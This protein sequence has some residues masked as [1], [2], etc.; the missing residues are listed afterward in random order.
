MRQALYELLYVIGLLV[1]VP[2]GIWRMRLPHRGWRMRLG[3]YD[4]EVRRRLEGRRSIW[5]HAVSVG[6]T[7]AAQPLIHGLG[8][9][10]PRH[11]LVLS[12]VTPSGFSVA[13]KGLDAKGVPIYFPLDL[14]GCV[15]RALDAI[16]PRILLLMES[17]LWPTVI[18]LTKA[19]GIPIAVV[20]GR[21]SPRAFRRYR[22]VPRWSAGTLRDVDLFLM[23]SQEDADRITQL[24]APSQA[25]RVVGNLKWEASSGTRPSPDALRSTAARLGLNG[26]EPL[27]VAGS[28]HRGEEDALL[29]AFQA[30]RT[31]HSTLRLIIAP[32]HLERLDEI[33]ALIRER[34]FTSARCSQAPSGAWEVGLVDTFG[35]LPTYYGLAH[36]VFVGG[37][38]IPHGGQNPLEPASLGKPVLFGPSMH[39]FSTI[40]HQLLSR[41]AAR[42]LSGRTEL[43]PALQEFLSNGRAAHTMGHR[44]QELVEASRGTTRRILEALLP[45]FAVAEKMTEMDVEGRHG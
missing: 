37:S 1:Y 11:P 7:L 8:Q 27:I 35:H 6:E 12:A 31:S 44:A 36:V 23:Q 33:E 18:R 3:R 5:I 14:R 42:Q 13:A 25:V 4:P 20:N 45:L 34:G 30:L 24:G 22:R 17:E 19:R 41:R 43:T 26:Q 38:L 2:R 10:Y 28:T 32:R 9:A 40:V 15:R 39:N 21:I 29:E 16:R